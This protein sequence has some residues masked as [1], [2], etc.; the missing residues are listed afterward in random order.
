MVRGGSG[1]LIVESGI[2]DITSGVKMFDSTNT[3]KA[4]EAK[5]V[6]ATAHTDTHTNTH[7][8]IMFCGTTA[9][10]HMVRS[11]SLVC[12]YLMTSGITRIFPTQSKNKSP[13]TQM[14]FSLNKLVCSIA[15]CS[16]HSSLASSCPASTP[17]QTQTHKSNAWLSP[18]NFCLG[19]S[20]CE[21]HT[22]AHIRGHVCCEWSQRLGQSRE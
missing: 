22:C 5:P 9:W 10:P 11:Q 12:Y 2:P 14:E 20:P 3:V 13:A 21:A 8:P 18:H 4:I 15:F 7:A 1:G 19:C 17:A 16:V 6:Y